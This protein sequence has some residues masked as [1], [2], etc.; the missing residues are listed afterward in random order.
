MKKI[1]LRYFF[2]K[3]QQSFM[4]YNENIHICQKKIEETL[5]LVKYLNEKINDYI[6]HNK[7][8]KL[9]SENELKQILNLIKQFRDI[10]LFSNSLYYSFQLTITFN[11]INDNLETGKYIYDSNIFGTNIHIN[12]INL[13]NTSGINPLNTTQ[14][15]LLSTLYDLRIKNNLNLNNNYILNTESLSQNQK[16]PNQL[17]SNTPPN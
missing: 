8:M 14:S 2:G 9:F 5:N 4:K 6:N 16:L 7:Q 17:H 10:S 1:F 15:Y 12:N 11:H 3:D 13:F